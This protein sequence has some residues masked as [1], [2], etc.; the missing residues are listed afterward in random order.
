MKQVLIALALS[1]GFAVSAQ[2]QTPPAPAHDHT[3]PPPVSVDDTKYCVAGNQLY[4]E[5][6]TLNGQTC[7][8][9]PQLVHG[10][11]VPMPKVAWQPVGVAKAAKASK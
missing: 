5:G 11:G 4:S 10:D 1:A 6:F 3:P 2:A 8:R 9:E 7:K